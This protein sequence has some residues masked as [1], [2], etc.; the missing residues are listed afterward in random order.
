MGKRQAKRPNMEDLRLKDGYDML[1]V[2]FGVMAFLYFL[3]MV[4]VG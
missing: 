3:W 1:A 4:T 2:M